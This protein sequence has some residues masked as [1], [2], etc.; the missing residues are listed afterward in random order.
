[1][2]IDGFSSKCFNFKYYRKPT[3]AF[4]YLYLVYRR[5]DGHDK[6]TFYNQLKQKECPSQTTG[7]F[8]RHQC[9]IC[10]YSTNNVGHL[11]A[12]MLTH[13]GI[14]PFVCPHCGKGFTQKGNLQRHIISHLTT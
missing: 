9:A 12:H 3:L 14:R 7:R 11:Q 1:M 2:S 6:L 4:F 5:T 13:S 8:K 10:Q